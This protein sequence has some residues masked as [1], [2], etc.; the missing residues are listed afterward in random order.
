LHLRVG[1]QIKQVNIIGGTL[2]SVYVE[3]FEGMLKEREVKK[4][5]TTIQKERVR[6]LLL[7]SWSTL[8]SLG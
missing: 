1:W 4:A 8:G 2:G 6:H 3:A 7:R 5:W